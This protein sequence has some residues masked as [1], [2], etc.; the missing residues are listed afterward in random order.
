MKMNDMMVISVDDHVSEPPDMFDKHLSG[1]ALASAPKM[2]TTAAGTNYWE[3]QGLKMPQ[4]GLNAVVGRVP[5]EYGMEPTSL[6]QLRK[7][8]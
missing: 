1:D 8:V 3:Y 6:E 4:V 5:E 2:R 7:G